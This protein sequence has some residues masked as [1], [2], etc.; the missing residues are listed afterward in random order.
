MLRRGGSRARSAA[1]ANIL[2]ARSLRRRFRRRRTSPSSLLSLSASALR[3]GAAAST[4]S[5]HSP[6]SSQP[7][8]SRA[9]RRWSCARRQSRHDGG[10][11]HLPTAAPATAASAQG[12]AV[13]PLR[14][15]RTTHLFPALPLAR[16]RVALLATSAHGFRSPSV[17]TASMETVASF[18]STHS[19]S[20]RSYRPSP[21]QRPS[22]LHT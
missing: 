19:T 12:V 11:T 6:P 17:T 3:S 1:P 15:E 8:R 2:A 9:P 5:P 22:T 10:R 18:V 14:P 7:P 16:R 20:R 13:G 4:G 21:M